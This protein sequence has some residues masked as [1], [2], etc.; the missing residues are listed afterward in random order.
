[1][2]TILNLLI[3]EFKLNKHSQATS[4]FPDAPLARLERSTLPEQKGTRTFV[5]RFL[6]II[7]L[8]KRA[9]PLYDGYVHCPKE[10]ELHWKAHYNN[11]QVWSLNIDKS[12]F[13]KQG[14]QLLW[15]T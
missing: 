15:D 1:L 7:E 5:L 10:G 6:K 13:L 4:P 8:V 14:L 12:K 2:L 11:Q 3:F 9:M